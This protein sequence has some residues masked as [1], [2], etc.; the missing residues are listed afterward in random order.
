MNRK[1]LYAIFKGSFRDWIEDNAV[2]RAAALTFFII[3]CQHF[4]LL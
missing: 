4:Y 2:L 1:E 3:L